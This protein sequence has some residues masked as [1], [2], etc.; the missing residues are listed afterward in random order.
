MK[1]VFNE[2]KKKDSQEIYQLYNNDN[3]NDNDNEELLIKPL[4]QHNKNINKNFG[5]NLKNSKFYVD[6]F[7]IHCESRFKIKEIITLN[8]SSLK[9]FFYILIN[10]FT[11]GIINIIIYYY[12]SLK[13]YLLFEEVEIEESSYIGIYCEDGIFYIEKINKYLLPN[14]Q[15]VPLKKYVLSN[16]PNNNI[17]YTFVFKYFKYIYNEDKSCFCNICFNLNGTEDEIIKNFWY[18]L[19]SNE[20]EYQKIIYGKNE[21]IIKMD[22]YFKLLINEFK[23]PFYIYII[24]SIILWIKNDY[25]L[26]SIIILIFFIFLLKDNILEKR[27]NIKNLTNLSNNSYK[28]IVNQRDINNNIIKIEKEAN[29]LVPGDMYELI[30]ENQIIPCDSVLIYGNAL[31]DESIITGESH[32]IYKSALSK[33]NKIFDHQSCENNILYSGT[34]IIKTYIPRNLD[35]DKDIHHPI[36]LVIGTSFWSKKWNI[37]RSI[38]YPDEKLSKNKF[39]EDKKKFILILFLYSFFGIIITLKFLINR[40]LKKYEILLKLLDIITIIVPPIFPICIN[41]GINNSIKRLKK[42]NIKCLNKEKI[43]ISGTIDTICFEP[44]DILCEDNIYFGGIQPVILYNEERIIFDKIYHNL[45]E[46]ILKGYNNF[47]KKANINNNNEDIPNFNEDYNQLFI[48]CMACCNIL[49]FDKEGNLIGDLIDLKMFKTSKWKYK[50]YDGGIIQL[51]L[52]PPQENELQEKINNSNNLNDIEE[53]SN[54]KTQYEIGIVK[55]FTNSSKFQKMSCLVKNMNNKDY[56]LFVKGSP[57]IIQELCE[58]NSLPENYDEILNNNIIEGNQVIALAYNPWKNINFKNIENININ[59]YE[60]NLKFL[61]FFIIKNKLKENANHVISKLNK[62]KYKILLSTYKDTLT[63]INISK[64]IKIIKPEDIIFTIDILNND[65]KFKHVENYSIV[66]EFQTLEKFCEIES[67]MKEK[68]LDNTYLNE[69]YN[70]SEFNSTKDNINYNNENIDNNEDKYLNLELKENCLESLNPSINKNIM[71]IEGKTF[72]KIYLL[73]NKY[74]ST[75]ENK[76]YLMYYNAFNLIIN[77]CRLFS[78]MNS[79]QKMILIKCLKEKGNVICTC[80]NNINDFGSLKISDIG[81]IF[82]RE[83]KITN[84]SFINEENDINSIIYLLKEGKSSLVSSIQIFKILVIYSFIQFISVLIVLYYG[85]YFTNIQFLISDLF[86]IIP[87]CY[88]TSNS[89]NNNKLTYHK[90]TG[91]LFNYSTILSLIFQ[92][93]LI[94]FF[95]LLSIII[96]NVKKWNLSKNLYPSYDNSIIFLISLFQYLMSPITF[97]ITYPFKKSIFRNILLLLYIIIGFTYFAYIINDPDYFSLKYL[98]INSFPYSFKRIFLSICFL[99][100]VCSYLCESYLIPNIV[101]YYFTNSRKNEILYHN[102]SK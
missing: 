14:I 52:R 79:Y 32:Y 41:L 13:L 31:L 58:N 93:I 7:D 11:L 97:S 82:N 21:I 27:E 33:T 95:Q 85:V 68:K 37:I 23:N 48:E 88:L 43:N 78:G 66:E 20:M 74:L 1:E 39:N 42:Q 64:N 86:I 36:A 102:N 63:A 3:D 38:I 50:K 73:R 98:N 5:K 76:K 96:F 91:S 100:L 24:F 69:E 72:E 51:Y 81:V 56:K 40:N 28:V 90:L 70:L 22:S 30:G 65:I 94:I 10:I 46:N 54:I 77:K 49:N 99:N 47:K 57:E 35:Y 55:Y 9:K 12:P 29:D 25:I 6:E 59:N 67:D 45:N 44:T 84:S 8:Y 83:S 60:K 19:S 2:E 80:S 16:I 26:Y 17:I 92:I 89:E 87:I 53:N 62:E 15:K 101:F 75:N 61:G 18:G 34:K 4:L 71:I